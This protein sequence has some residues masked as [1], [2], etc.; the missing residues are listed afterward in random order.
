MLANVLIHMNASEK[1]TGRRC[2]HYT[3]KDLFFCQ[4]ELPTE[5]LLAPLLAVRHQLSY[6]WGWMPLTN[7]SECA[8]LWI[9]HVRGPSMFLLFLRRE[10]FQYV[11]QC[12]KWEPPRE[13]F[14]HKMV[15]SLHVRINLLQKHIN[16]LNTTHENVSSNLLKSVPFTSTCIPYRW[17][18]IIDN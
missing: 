14:L 1:S 15:P 17:L 6:F 5:V 2:I 4:G 10:I 8:A 3:K 12:P 18:M 11:S 7:L 9:N 13:V 16:A